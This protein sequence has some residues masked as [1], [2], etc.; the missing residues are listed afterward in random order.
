MS[1]EKNP[2][3]SGDNQPNKND[4]FLTQLNLA[5]FKV[6]EVSRLADR[7]HKLD[8]RVKIRYK[9]IGFFRLLV[10]KFN[11]N[12]TKKFAHLSIS[13]NEY[14]LFYI[15]HYF[16]FW[17]KRH[18][19][20]KFSKSILFNYYHEHIQN[21]VPL[22]VEI[23]KKKAIKHWSKLTQKLIEN[24]KQQLI[25]DV[26]NKSELLSTLQY[27]FNIWYDR[28]YNRLQIKQARLNKWYSLTDKFLAKIIRDRL[29]KEADHI[30]RHKNWK[31]M[32]KAYLQ[33]RT[34]E[35][36]HKLHSR[37]LISSY[38][39]QLAKRYRKKQQR[40]K[41]EKAALRLRLEN[42]WIYLS[43]TL[44][45]N[46]KRQRLDKSKLASDAAAKVRSATYQLL[47]DNQVSRLK[48][49]KKRRQEKVEARK[50]IE[51]FKRYMVYWFNRSYIRR[52]MRKSY[53]SSIK[54]Y[55]FS[56][57]DKS[58]RVIQ[59]WFRSILQKQR[60][61]QRLLFRIFMEWRKLPL[62]ITFNSV[63]FPEV[64]IPIHTHIKFNL[65]MYA[66]KLNGDLSVLTSIYERNMAY[67]SA[68]V[69]E[70]AHCA[71]NSIQ[72][73]IIPKPQFSVLPFSG[74][75]YISHAMK[76]IDQKKQ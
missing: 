26:Y 19:W 41:L 64:N 35:N 31:S 76:T 71:S 52:F 15:G 32:S 22:I 8:E 6:Y 72:L 62:R 24:D 60:S 23:K 48:E 56:V 20:V 18:S 29:T 69:K 61:R 13:F 5:N 33:Q 68:L 54:E 47:H 9:W 63:E 25:K 37:Y 67:K 30:Q 21:A 65:D 57:C 53:S 73:D 74:A 45:S 12:C 39:Y 28:Y 40:D 46:Y 50:R 43:H 16:Y 36:I 58:A 10:H 14:N 51:I 2:E 17:K 3:F 34:I 70:I 75:R 66:P 55:Q 49:E 27:F 38:I 1:T 11:I 44:L 42:E 4:I 7:I 59:E